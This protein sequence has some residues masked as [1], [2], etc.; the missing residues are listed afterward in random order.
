MCGIQWRTLIYPAK[1]DR[2]Q[3]GES[4]SEH[5]KT[6]CRK[7]EKSI[8]NARMIHQSSFDAIHTIQGIY[9]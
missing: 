7:R 6:N 2:G 1:N 3:N 8:I 9:V 5:T 4:R